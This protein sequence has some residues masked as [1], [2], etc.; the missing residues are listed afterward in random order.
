M[1]LLLP[2]L[3]YRIYY[4]III[5]HRP[6]NPAS[7]L[8]YPLPHIYVTSILMLYQSPHISTAISDAILICHPCHL[9]FM[10][11]LSSSTYISPA[12]LTLRHIHHTTSLPPPYLLS[13]ISV[14]SLLT[15]TWLRSLCSDLICILLLRT[16]YFFLK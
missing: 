11:P 6:H 9:A 1:S 7:I 14:A 3:S 16:F 8:L 2:S 4:A 15:L 12:I 13:Y 5:F 10:I